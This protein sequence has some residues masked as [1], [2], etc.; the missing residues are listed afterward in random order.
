MWQT[1]STTSHSAMQ[2][3]SRFL[4]PGG[5]RASPL[6]SSETARGASATELSEGSRRPLHQADHIRWPP[7]PAG[8]G[9]VDNFDRFSGAADPALVAPTP[10]APPCGGGYAILAWRC[11]ET[12]WT[13]PSEWLMPTTAV[14]SMACSPSSRPPTS[15]GTR[16]STGPSTGAATADARE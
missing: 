15:S 16:E 5:V 13:L 4:M 14:M 7:G 3:S 10:L 1:Q 9:V 8:P 6:E 2:H 12:K 11:R